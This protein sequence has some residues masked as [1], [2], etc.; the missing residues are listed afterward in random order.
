MSTKVKV[1]LT[2]EEEYHL[3][4]VIRG[5]DKE[6]SREAKEKLFQSLHFLVASYV[7]DVPPNPLISFKE[8]FKAGNKG[9]V[10]ALSHWKPEY[11]KR[12]KFSSYAIWW[13]R[14]EIRDRLKAK[15][16]MSTS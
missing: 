16:E 4:R 10:T 1:Y 6:K 2:R 9:V 13:I 7:C 15:M 12:Y 3:L 14:K 8:L 5:S 11:E